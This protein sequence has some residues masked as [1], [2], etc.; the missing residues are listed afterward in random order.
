VAPIP[1]QVRKEVALKDWTV[2]GEPTVDGQHT[3]R[4]REHG[5][6][7]HPRLLTRAATIPAGFPP[8]QSRLQFPVSPDSITTPPD[9]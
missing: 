5:P 2:L 4:L 1:A 7:D 3:I 9:I 8:G 6:R